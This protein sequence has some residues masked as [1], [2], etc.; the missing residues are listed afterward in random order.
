MTSIWTCYPGIMCFVVYHFLWNPSLNY[1]VRL[2]LMLIGCYAGLLLT[3]AAISASWVSYRA[4]FPY[5]TWNSLAIKSMPILLKQQLQQAISRLDSQI[6]FTCSEVFPITFP[7]FSNIL[8]GLATYLLL[9]A[10]FTQ[11]FD[12]VI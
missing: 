8:L 7:N 5:V 11:E 10:D 6:G 9:V 12:R 3:L 1:F 4:H 2:A